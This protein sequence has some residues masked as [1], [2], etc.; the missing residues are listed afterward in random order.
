MSLYCLIVPCTRATLGPLYNLV[1]WFTRN[2]FI[3]HTISFSY[4]VTLVG[5][6]EQNCGIVQPEGR[7]VSKSVAELRVFLS[8]AVSCLLGG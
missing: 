5:E 1:F 4:K 6:R 2:R 7:I 3:L 8:G